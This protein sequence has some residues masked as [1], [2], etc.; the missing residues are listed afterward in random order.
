VGFVE[1]SL[2]ISLYKQHVLMLDS[3]GIFLFAVAADSFRHC[4]LIFS[5]LK[6]S[7]ALL[8]DSSSGA[9]STCAGSICSNP[10]V[11]QVCVLAPSSTWSGYCSFVVRS[12]PLLSYCF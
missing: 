3:V 2:K 5:L 7:H 8:A 1:Q 10:A 9:C 4:L 12:F 6:C 11:D